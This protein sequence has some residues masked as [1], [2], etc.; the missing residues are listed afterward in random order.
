ME[1][2]SRS[3]ESPRLGR[4]RDPFLV[5]LT[6]CP[7]MQPSQFH[8]RNTWC[9]YFLLNPPSPML[10]EIRG[11]S[12]PG[13]PRQQ[14]HVWSLSS[15]LCPSSP[16]STCLPELLSPDANLVPVLSCSTG[17]QC[18]RAKLKFSACQNNSLTLRPP[19]PTPAPAPPPA[20]PPSLLQHTEVRCL[21]PFVPSV[22]QSE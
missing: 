12:C 15:S 14:L 13:E 22:A 18:W 1:K 11:P 3:H 17:P 16:F 5:S 6:S 8:L 7:S 21:H 20:V 2:E 9:M 10:L 19:P 4:L